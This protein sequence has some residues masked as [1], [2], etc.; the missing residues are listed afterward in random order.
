MENYVQE[1]FKTTRS[2]Q[3][4]DTLFRKCFNRKEMPMK[5]ENYSQRG[6]GNITEAEDIG[7]NQI[8]QE[9]RQRV[10][11]PE[12]LLEFDQKESTKTLKSSR[13]QIS[14]V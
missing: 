4:K 3:L 11:K 7:Y 6:G 14:G 10:T 12:S 2:K 8:S 5:I 1:K 13:M 9:Q